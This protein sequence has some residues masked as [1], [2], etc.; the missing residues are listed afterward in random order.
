MGSG[1][2]IGASGEKDGE[3]M[4]EE[5][6]SGAESYA[7]C[8]REKRGR[9]HVVP[10]EILAASHHGIVPHLYLHNQLPSPRAFRVDLGPMGLF[11]GADRTSTQFKNEKL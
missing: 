2:I 4:R 11:Q 7:L 9:D 3:S 5:P 8:E 1:S 6:G 10:V